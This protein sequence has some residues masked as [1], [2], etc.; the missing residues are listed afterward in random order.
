MHATIGHTHHRYT[1][2]M[3]MQMCELCSI[4]FETHYC[5][6]LYNTVRVCS[7]AVNHFI[8]SP[9]LVS[10]SSFH[11]IPLLL[12]LLLLHLLLL[13]PLLLLLLLSF[14]AGWKRSWRELLSCASTGQPFRRRIGLWMRTPDRGILTCIIHVPLRDNPVVMEHTH[15]DCIVDWVIFLC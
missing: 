13:S 9:F 4:T 10:L 5:T 11:L 15:T 6:K 1:L 2:C 8:K 14:R 3:I 12:S 7:L